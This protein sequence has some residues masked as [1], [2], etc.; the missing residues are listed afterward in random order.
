MPKFIRTTAAI[1]VLGFFTG[2]AHSQAVIASI[3]GAGGNAGTTYLS[4]YI[5]LFNPTA[6]AVSLSGWSVQYA[7]ATG[8]SWS[9]LTIL[10]NF[11]LQS[12]QYF[13]IQEASGGAVGSALP[14][15]DATGNINLS[16]NAGKVAL[17]STTNL[18]SGTNSTGTN[19]V[20]FVGYGSTANSYE[21]SGPAPAPSATLA[22]IRKNNGYTDTN[23]NAADFTTGAANPLNSSSVPEPATLALL[24]LGGVLAWTLRRR[25]TAQ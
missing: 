12:G 11:S 18:L 16:T 25:L 3:Y 23:D 1:L 7:S 17:A 8:T 20:D 15:P 10:P 21:G 19:I 2:V 4:D 6:S 24:S 5:V 14:T 9:G 22:L 13:L